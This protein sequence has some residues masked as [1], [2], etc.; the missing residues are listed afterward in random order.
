MDDARRRATSAPA[1][2]LR[3]PRGRSVRHSGASIGGV[4][5][6]AARSG[7]A[8]L[9]VV[10]LSVAFIPAVTPSEVFIRVVIPPGRSSQ[11]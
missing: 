11:R 10:A 1:A 7:A 4:G 3:A 6:A 5:H 8:F 9:R 2:A